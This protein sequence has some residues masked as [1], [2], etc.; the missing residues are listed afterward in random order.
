MGKGI[1]SQDLRQK[2]IV[3]KIK[4]ECILT[5]SAF[6]YLTIIYAVM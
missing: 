3:E 6:D 2:T 4:T 5:N 1:L